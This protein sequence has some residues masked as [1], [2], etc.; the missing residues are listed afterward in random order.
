MNLDYSRPYHNKSI[1]Q[2]RSI[3][4]RGGLASAR[5]RRLRARC[6]PAPTVEH[7]PPQETAH[8]ASMLLDAKFP[9]LA[10]AQHPFSNNSASAASQASVG[11][12]ASILATF[13][14]RVLGTDNPAA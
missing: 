4:R 12:L 8:E 1:D 2:C 5:T 3:G 10:A 14:R 6:Q 13:A 7:A 11:S 9:W